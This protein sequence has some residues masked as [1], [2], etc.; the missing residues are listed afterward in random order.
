MQRITDHFPLPWSPLSSK[1]VARIDGLTL[2]EAIDRLDLPE[3]QCQLLRSFWALI[4][5][6]SLDRAAYSQALR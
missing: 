2:S 5:N 3:H 1:E 4:F 6:G